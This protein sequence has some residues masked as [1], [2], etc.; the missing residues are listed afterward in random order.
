[1]TIGELKE[2]IK[3]IPNNAEIRISDYGVYELD[4]AVQETR[5]EKKQG[6]SQDKTV[7]YIYCF[8]DSDGYDYD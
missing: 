4:L 5:T 6:F 2:K 8:D 7:F 3:D 1:M